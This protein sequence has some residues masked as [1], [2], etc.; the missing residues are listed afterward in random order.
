[1]NTVLYLFENAGASYPVAGGSTVA[2]WVANNC[3]VHPSQ[4][5]KW[6]VDLLQLHFRV[7]RIQRESRSVFASG[8]VQGR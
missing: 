5:A 1:M 8:M 6:F 3:R 4:V 2:V 7:H